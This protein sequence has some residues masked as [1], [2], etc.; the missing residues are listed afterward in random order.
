MNT[1]T[2]KAKAQL[3]ASR[4]PGKQ[5][6]VTPTPGS[7]PGCRKSAESA[8]SQSPAPKRQKAQSTAK[9]TP[10]TTA[11]DTKQSRLI[12]LMRRPAGATLAELTEAT[13]WQPHSV[14]GAISGVLRKRHGLTVTLQQ[15]AG[16]VAAYRI[17]A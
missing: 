14:R 13:G 12:A 9:T 5:A 1:K 3:D 10:V 16:G 2:A 11:I 7:K 15:Q 17:Q 6:T 8:T 4:I